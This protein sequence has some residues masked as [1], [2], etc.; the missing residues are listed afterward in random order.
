[1]QVENLFTKIPTHFGVFLYMYIKI[2]VR[3]QDKTVP[4]KDSPT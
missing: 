4:N 1:M 3:R 2:G